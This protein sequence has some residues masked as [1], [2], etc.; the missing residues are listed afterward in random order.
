[1]LW[2]TDIA[3]DGFPYFSWILIGVHVG[4]SLVFT[5]YIQEYGGDALK[6]WN[7]TAETVP[8][9]HSWMQHWG[10][11]TLFVQWLTYPFSHIMGLPFWLVNLIYAGLTLWAIFRLYAIA[12]SILILQGAD[13]MRIKALQ[14]VFLLP[15]LHFW[16]AGIGKESLAFVALVLYVVGW[17][18]RPYAWIYLLAAIA[19]SWMV[20]PLQGAVLAIFVPFWFFQANYSTLMKGGVLVLTALLFIP[21]YQYLQLISH[22]DLLSRA[23]IQAFFQ[24]QQEFLAGFQAG[25]FVDMQDYAWWEVVGTFLFRPLLWEGGSFWQVAA[26]LENTL[27]LLFFGVF[28][29]SLLLGKIP[30]IFWPVLVASALI[31]T[32]YAFSLNNF[33]IM[34]RM[35]SIFMIFIYVGAIL[36]LHQLVNAFQKYKHT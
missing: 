35:K 24:G 13:G 7:L 22:V 21:I 4:I 12:A 5:W 14:L 6:Y 36:G 31:C 1:M 16:T 20:R 11:R 34:M 9:P 32:V 30:K 8:D 26:A 23:G 25:S 29:F 27:L 15:N 3:G 10:T 2:K 28:V 33:G 17:T 19:L 18:H